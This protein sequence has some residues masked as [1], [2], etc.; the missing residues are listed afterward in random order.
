MKLGPVY[1]LDK[2]KTKTKTKTKKKK[3]IQL[4][5]ILQKVERELKNL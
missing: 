3:Q 4:H 2:K 1:K 5:F